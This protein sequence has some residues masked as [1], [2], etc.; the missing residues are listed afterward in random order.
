MSPDRVPG[1]DTE[2]AIAD[3]E[4]AVRDAGLDPSPSLAAELDR[5]FDAHRDRVRRLCLRLT[6]DP[7]RADELVQE[8]LLVAWR[9]L[10]EFHGGARFSTW[11]YGIAR[12]LCLNAVRKRSELL[13]EDG[14]VEANDPAA[15]ALRR[16]QRGERERLVRE[17]AAALDPQEQEAVHLRYVLGLPLDRIDE[18]LGL[19]GSGARGLL[20]RCRRKLGREVARRLAELGHGR[21]FLYT[22]V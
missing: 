12:N 9:R 6:G 4:R 11:I 13:T 22:D 17:A 3:R 8:T 7:Q 19:R 16:L 21:S 1:P 15:D 10:P 14:V 2:L 18:L 20:Q 5:L